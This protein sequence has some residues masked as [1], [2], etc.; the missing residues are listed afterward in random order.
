MIMG[1]DRSVT[2]TRITRFV[3]A[4][5][6]SKAVVSGSGASMVVDEFCVREGWKRS[7]ADRMQRTRTATAMATEN[8]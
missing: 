8:G 2:L 3:W 7:Q 6:A 1:E 5:T 4:L